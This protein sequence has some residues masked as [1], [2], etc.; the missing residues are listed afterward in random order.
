M[1]TKRQVERLTHKLVRRKQC[2]G[3]GAIMKGK[4]NKLFHIHHKDGNRQNNLLDNLA[5]LCVKC[6]CKAHQSL[7]PN[8]EIC[9]QWHKPRPFTVCFSRRVDIMKASKE[10]ARKMWADG[11]FR[12]CPKCGKIMGKNHSCA[13]PRGMKGKHHSFLTKIRISET[14]KKKKR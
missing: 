12:R 8:C 4:K 11:V 7:H 13:H 10:R 3:C 6:H 1:L 14:Q 2:E 9:G 5:V